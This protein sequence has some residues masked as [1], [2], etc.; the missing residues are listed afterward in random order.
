M[1]QLNGR[2]AVVTGGASGNGRG[3]VNRFAAEGMKV[4]VADVEED[5]LDQVVQAVR[6][7]RFYVLTHPD[8]AL[9]DIRQRPQ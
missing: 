4:V 1:R 2:V 6:E 7:N 5:P 8:V 3:L 9:A